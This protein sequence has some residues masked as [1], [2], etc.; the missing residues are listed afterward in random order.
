MVTTECE[1]YQVPVILK[2]KY[3]TQSRHGDVSYL[4][5]ILF[6]ENDNKLNDEVVDL[7]IYSKSINDRFYMNISKQIRLFEDYP[8]LDIVFIA[9]SMITISCCIVYLL[10]FIGG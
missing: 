6:Y 2:E 9:I 1:Y 10:G 5:A 8:F 7:N 3:V 4:H